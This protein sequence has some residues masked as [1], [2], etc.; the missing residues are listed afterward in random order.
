MRAGLYLPTSDIDAV[1]L[2]SGCRD[3]RQG[4]KALA[5]A[6]HRRDMA[7]NVQVIAKA[8]VPIVKFVER[9]S[10]FQ[11]DVSF[12]VANG[13][14]VRPTPALCIHS[15]PL[16]AAWLGRLTPPSSLECII[17]GL[18]NDCRAHR[19]IPKQRR[20]WPRLQH[21]WQTAGA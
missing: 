8:K 10:G 11:F 12:D 16:P 21:T 13:P 14:A 2:H 5:N 20:C 1:L 6:L 19:N 3:P 9:E 15:R 17:V 7:T 4:L 18:E